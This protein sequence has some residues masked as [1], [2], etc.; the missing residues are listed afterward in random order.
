MN[1]TTRRDAGACLIVMSNVFFDMARKD[2]HRGPAE[3]GAG[4]MINDS[5]VEIYFR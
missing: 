2:T 4:A 5:S 1:Q 3:V